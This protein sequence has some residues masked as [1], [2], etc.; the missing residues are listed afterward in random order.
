MKFIA[1]LKNS[2]SAKIYERY[3]KQYIRY[4]KNDTTRNKV[5]QTT[6]VTY[7]SMIATTGKYSLGIMLCIC[8]YLKSSIIVKYNANI[9][10][11]MLLCK[12]IK[13]TT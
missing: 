3:Q 11:M 6:L 1:N 2:K 13:R 4:Y 8:N 12:I 5:S 7:F 10:S 9:K